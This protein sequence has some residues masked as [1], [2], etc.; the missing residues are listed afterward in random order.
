MSENPEPSP[1]RVVFFGTAEFACP[2]LVALEQDPT[3]EVVGVVSQ[4]DRPRGRELRMHPPAVKETAQHLGLKVWQPAKCRAPEFVEQIA[5]VAPACLVV[6][7]YGQILPP[8]LLGLP[9]HGC[10]NIHGSLLPKYRGAAPIQWALADG[11]SETGVTIMRM[12]TGLD[13]GPMLATEST[14][15]WPDDNAQ[16]LHDRL[17]TLG[18]DLLL[19]TLP[20]YLAGAITPQPQPPEGATY[21]RKI[22]REDGRVDWPLPATVVARRVRAFTPWPGAFTHLP[23]KSR[24]LLKILSAEALDREIEG[25]QP[26]TILKAGPESLLVA[27]GSGVLQIH[28]VQREGAR[29][30]GVDAFLAG[31]PLDPGTRFGHL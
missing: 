29:R 15:I 7:A 30:V 26:G 2:A 1:P 6:A 16:S 12:D 19:R 20:H 17:A 4:P 21:A 8:A 9:A 27:C 13:T 25:A 18:A 10:V 28:E 23:T 3:F 22:T 24:R 31:F 11:E 14:P 5:S